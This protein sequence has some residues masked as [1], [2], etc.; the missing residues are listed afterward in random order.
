MLTTSLSH[1][2]PLPIGERDAN[3]L[4][5]HPFFACVGMDWEG[6]ADGRIQ[7]PWY[8]HFPFIYPSI[9]DYFTF[10]ILF[11]ILFFY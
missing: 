1:S 6:L 3:E 7:P 9:L 2:L 10:L 8:N 5:E 4:K 11:I